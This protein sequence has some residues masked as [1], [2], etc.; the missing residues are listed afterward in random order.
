MTTVSDRGRN[1]GQDDVEIVPAI[2]GDSSV[3]KNEAPDRRGG[4]GPR[5]HR[6]EIRDQIRVAAHDAFVEHGYDATTMRSIAHQVGCDPAMVSYY[7]GS[8]QRLFRECFN[9]P[10]DPAQ[11]V[12]AQF[13]PGIEGAGERLIRHGLTLYDERVTAETMHALMHSL[14]TDAATSQRFRE[15]I[16]SEILEKVHEYLNSGSEVSEQIE[17]SMAFVYG[18]AT[19]RYIVK[20]EPLASMPRERLIAELAPIIQSRIDRVAGRYPEKTIGPD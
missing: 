18:I 16:R 19:M 12:L 13:I 3:A 6:G 17:L 7:F 2:N 14:M 9:L 4:R 11:E 15:Y 5:G 10:S 1:D 20:L 8:K